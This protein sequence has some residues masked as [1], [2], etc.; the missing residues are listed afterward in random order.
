M[1]A[2]AATLRKGQVV[3]CVDPLSRRFG[4]RGVVLSDRIRR[5]VWLVDVLWAGAAYASEEYWKAIAWEAA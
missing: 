1:T 4:W 3:V 2:E 5:G